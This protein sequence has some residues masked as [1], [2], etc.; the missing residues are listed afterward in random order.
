MARCLFSQ[1]AH[2]ELIT[3]K[4]DESLKFFTQVLGLEETARKG[5]SVYLRGW[6]CHLHHELVLTAGREPRLG[7]I[8][9]RAAGPDELNTAVAR[10]EAAGAGSGWHDDTPGHGP[11]FRFTNPGGHAQE[12]FWETER[13]AP[14]P[15]LAPNYPNR[16]QRFSPRGVAARYLDHVTVTSQNIMDNFH[17][18][19]DTL[20]FR[21]M[22][23]TVLDDHPDVPIFGML[24]TCERAHDLGMVADFSPIPGRLHH[25]SFWLDQIGDVIRAADILLESGTRVEYGP[26]KHGMG[27]QTFLYFR[28]PGGLRLELNSGGYRNYMPDW[29]TVKWTPGQGSNDFYLHNT[30]PPSMMQSFPPDQP[31]DQAA[32]PWAAGRAA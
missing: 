25:V 12:V 28:E 15:E 19:R 6:G 32:N 5:E 8:G 26:G 30:S 17:W 11:A 20:G 21:F 7:H 27:E 16:P 14:P 22:E 29:Q 1:L 9:W 2:V 18:Y 31:A 23:W 4:P 24:T 10:L 13:F 3:P